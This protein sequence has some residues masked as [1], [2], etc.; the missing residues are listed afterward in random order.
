MQALKDWTYHMKRCGGII[1]DAALKKQHRYTCS[2]LHKVFNTK[3]ALLMHLLR[4]YYYNKPNKPR[5]CPSFYNKNPGA[6]RA[7]L[8]GPAVIR[9]TSSDNSSLY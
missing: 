8:P 1:D 2:I 4:Y 9:N 6:P 7:T 5:A 3:E